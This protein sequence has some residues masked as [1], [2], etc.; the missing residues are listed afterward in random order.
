MIRLPH[1]VLVLGLVTGIT[2]GAQPILAQSLS[3][4]RST[5]V[6]GPGGR[7]IERR[8]ETSRSPGTLERQVQIQRPAGT[9]ERS[10]A[11]QRGFPGGPPPGRGPGPGP[12]FGAPVPWGGPRPSSAWS[13][14][15]G[16]SEERV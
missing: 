1:P 16:R 13:V 8:V 12:W 6:T 3:R 10:V 2:T 14:G 4:E 7:T 5:S 11:I 15:V 9:F